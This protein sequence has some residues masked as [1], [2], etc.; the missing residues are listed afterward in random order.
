MALNA[1]PATD[2]TMNAPSAHGASASTTP[3]VCP[4]PRPPAKRSHGFQS[5]ATSTAM[6]AAACTPPPCPA[7][8]AISTAA[9]PCAICARPTGTTSA[10]DT[11]CQTFD[12]PTLPLPNS[13][14]STPFV[15]RPV[16]YGMGTDPMRYA[17]TT[18]AVA[19]SMV[20]RMRPAC[21]RARGSAR[22]LARARSCARPRGATPPRSPGRAPP[23]VRGCAPATSP[24]RSALAGARRR[25]R[26]E[27][28]RAPRRSR[29]TRVGALRQRGSAP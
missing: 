25:R 20:R 9:S 2:T 12:A 22:A 28:I 13:R 15:M 11:L 4:T 16:R 23:G 18:A 8:L 14:I 3:I 24:L 6:P 21:G 26:P 5:L 17:A 29:E 7:A 27:P 1:T 10:L 19:A